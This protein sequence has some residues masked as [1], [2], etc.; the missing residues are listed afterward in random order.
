VARVGTEMLLERLTPFENSNRIPVT[1]VD[2]LLPDL[3]D[4]AAVGE[5]R[6][7]MDV[8]ALGALIRAVGFAM[9]P[10]IL[11][12]LRG[13]TERYLAGNLNERTLRYFKRKRLTSLALPGGVPS[14]L[15]FIP[16]NATV[17]RMARKARGLRRA[18]RR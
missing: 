4:R 14:Q 12:G 15:A 17:R 1:V 7:G 2:A 18:V 3:G 16:R 5:R 8:A 13:G 9:Q 6:P 11:P 10:K